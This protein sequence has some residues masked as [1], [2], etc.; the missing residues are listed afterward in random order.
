MAA[1]PQNIPLCFLPHL[2]LSQQAISLRC[3]R[4]ISALVLIY[5][6]LSAS[7]KPNH[8][9]AERN[10]ATFSRTICP[11]R[12]APPSPFLP[13]ITGRGNGCQ[14]VCIFEVGRMKAS[15]SVQAQQ[16]VGQ[17]VCWGKRTFRTWQ[18]RVCVSLYLLHNENQNTDS[19]SKVRTFFQKGPFW[20]ICTNTKNC[21]KVKTKTKVG[22]ELGQDQGLSGLV[23]NRSLIIGKC[24]CVLLLVGSAFRWLPGFVAA[25]AACPGFCWGLEQCTLVL[26]GWNKKWI[27]T[28]LGQIWAIP[29]RMQP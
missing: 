10:L 29:V 12:P 21:L 26:S 20:W 5:I 7:W 17:C 15:S 22:L 28:P 1:F 6:P 4:E 9:P 8:L 25:V 13:F 14:S 23:R 3:H 27:L 19:T 24:L 2:V 18:A 16:Q 11:R